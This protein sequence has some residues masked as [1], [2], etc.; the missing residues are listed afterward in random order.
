VRFKA[1]EWTEHLDA[2]AFQEGGN[3]GTSDAIQMGEF[4]RVVKGHQ[5]LGVAKWDGEEKKREERR[6]IVYGL[7]VMGQGEGGILP[8]ETIAP[9]GSF[10]VDEQFGRCLCSLFF[11]SNVRPC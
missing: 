8:A 4:D 2:L 9:G 11:V 6:G 10:E 7:V 5:I 1:V 3:T